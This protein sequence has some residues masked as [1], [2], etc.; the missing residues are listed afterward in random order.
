M[1][2]II[3]TSLQL[4]FIYA[5]VSL[6]LFISYRIL[7]IADLS[8][9]GTFVLGMC[10]SVVLTYHNHPVLGLILA[11]L[12]GGL[13]GIITALLQTHLSIPSIL[14]GIISNT[15]L[16]T[17]NLMIMSYS[18][19]VSLIKQDTVFTLLNIPYSNIILPAILFIIITILLSLFLKTRLGLSIRATGDNSDMV[20]SSSIDPRFTTIVGLS[21][22]NCLTALAGGLIGQLQK[23]SDINSGTGIVVTGLACLI[24]GE[25]LIGKKNMTINMIA[26]LIGNIVYRLMYA[27]ILKTRLFPIEFLKLI[28]AIIIT[29]AIALPYIKNQAI[30]NKRSANNARTN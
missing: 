1:N 19:N 15:G 21:L 23:S 13:S 18:S 20:S 6:A 29:I 30:L 16:Y 11:L 28:T 2:F 4:G 7:D 10:V 9:D 5:L 3:E 8:T 27:I 12:S 26:V 25:S 24:I 14:A 22:A 17:I